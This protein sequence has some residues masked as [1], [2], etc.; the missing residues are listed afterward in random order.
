MVRYLVRG[1]GHVAKVADARF[2]FRRGDRGGCRRGV[3]DIQ[4][5]NAVPGVETYAALF[6]YNIEALLAAHRELN[7]VP[8]NPPAAETAR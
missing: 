7:G 3:G 5:V 4:E 6:Q 1:S 8:A 2:R